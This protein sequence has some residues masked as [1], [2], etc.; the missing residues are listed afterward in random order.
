MIFLKYF[1]GLLDV[2]IEVALAM[3]PFIIVFLGF[4]V[5]SL[6]LPKKRLIIILRGMGMTLLGLSF[7][8][9]GVYIGFLPA[10]EKM[11]LIMGA[12]SNNWI[13]IPIGFVLGF[14]TILAEPTV[15]VLTYEVEKATGGSIPEKVMV[16][17]LALGVGL[18]VGLTML[19]IVFDIPFVYF[20]VPAYIFAII[21]MQFSRENFIGMAVDA[22]GVAT[23]P[24]TVTFILAM[25]LGVATAIEGRD[26]LMDGFGLV[27]LVLIAPIISVL[28]LGVLYERSEKKNAASI[29]E[30]L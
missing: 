5:I 6:K 9:H 2:F 25:A 27:A 10:G 29:S 26:P 17:A 24:M 15:K 14:V 4:Q 7:F 16:I 30:K 21:L 11:G 23:G 20:I 1:D 13:L 8:L 22:G 12:M 19:R 3:A 18:S 28:I